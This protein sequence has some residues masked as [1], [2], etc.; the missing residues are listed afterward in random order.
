MKETKNKFKVGDKVRVN[1]IGEVYGRYYEW[2]NKYAKKY[3]KNWKYDGVITD[4][5]SVYE[6]KAFGPHCLVNRMLYLIQN[7]TN[8]EVYIIGE[9]GIELVPTKFKVGDRVKGHMGVGTVVEIG[10]DLGEYL[11]L[12]DKSKCGLHNGSLFS[13]GTYTGNK[14]WFYF[15][16]E[17]QLIEEKKFTKADLKAGDILTFRNGIKVYIDED[18]NTFKSVKNNEIGWGT[19]ETYRDDLTDTLGKEYDI[20]KV[21]KVAKQQPILDDVEREYLSGVIRPFRNRVRGIKK[22]KLII[23]DSK[24]FITIYLKDDAIHFPFFKANTMYKGMKVGK[25]YT[26]EELGL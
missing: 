14:C 8:K 11:V 16:S 9:K 1:N 25:E 2:I 22:S 15:E 20:V 24:E 5:Q 23:D 18:G 26:L 10:D 4:T 6:V 13:K 21:E 3:K 19:L 17:L 12:H 7:T